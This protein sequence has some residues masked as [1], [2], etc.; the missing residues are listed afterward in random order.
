M[1][2]ESFCKES[3][4]KHFYIHILFFR[5]PIPAFLANPKHPLTSLGNALAL[6]G[7]D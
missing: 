6:E 7:G 1:F 3:V 5:E 4:L 2:K